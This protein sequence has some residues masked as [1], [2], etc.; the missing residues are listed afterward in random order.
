[1]D[2]RQL[3]KAMEEHARQEAQREVSESL[4]T[5]PVEPIDEVVQTV[6]AFSELVEDDSD[7]S[8][9]MGYKSANIAKNYR[10]DSSFWQRLLLGRHRTYLTEVWNIEDD[11]SGGIT[12]EDK[13]WNYNNTLRYWETKYKEHFDNA[14]DATDFLVSDV[15]SLLVP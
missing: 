1:M 2:K 7:L 9:V 6:K 15:F 4:E 5:G 10:D 14:K 13:E 3:K 8:V 12:I 11:G